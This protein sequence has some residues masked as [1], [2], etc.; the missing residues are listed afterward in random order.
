RLTVWVFARFNQKVGDLACVMI[1]AA[2]SDRIVIAVVGEVLLPNFLKTLARGTAH[3]LLALLALVILAKIFF[4][5]SVRDGGL[6]AVPFVE[7]VRGVVALHQHYP[8]PH[9]HTFGAGADLVDSNI[10]ENSGHYAASVCLA[11][12]SRAAISRSSETHHRSTKSLKFRRSRGAIASKER[13]NGVL[14]SVPLT[15]RSPSD[16]YCV[17]LG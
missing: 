5:L 10:F 1:V 9:A 15:A 8:G 13:A 3:G 12:P 2:V 17:P 7:V 16:M 11:S 14:T 6:F 4:V